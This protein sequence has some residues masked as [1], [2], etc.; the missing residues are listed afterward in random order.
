MSGEVVAD[1]DPFTVVFDNTTDNHTAALLGFVVGAPSRRFN[2]LQPEQ[3]RQYALRSLVRWFGPEAGEPETVV[4]KDWAD[5]PWTR[6]CPIGV[7]GPL[8]L[9]VHGEALREP[10]D[11]IHWAGTETADVWMGF[12]EGAVRSG[13]RVADEIR[14]IE[15]S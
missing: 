3:Q 2:A 13:E 9:S 11:R 4:I 1:G 6:G 5:E 10:A 12:M 7:T 8:T 15:P 14:R